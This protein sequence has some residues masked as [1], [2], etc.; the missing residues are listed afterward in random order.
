M[1]PREVDVCG[2]LVRLERIY[3]VTENARYVQFLL[4]GV[5]SG[6]SKTCAGHKVCYECKCVNEKMLK[7]CFPRA[8]QP[9]AEMRPL[10]G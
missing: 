5:H 7:T 2:R 4:L 6:A 1:Y 10:R 3:I 8:G 9:R